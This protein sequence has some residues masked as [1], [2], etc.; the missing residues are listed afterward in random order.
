M[1][2]AMSFASRTSPQEQHLTLA[3]R[4]GLEP[5]EHQPQRDDQDDPQGER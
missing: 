5:I 4:I 2:S 1:V 3:A